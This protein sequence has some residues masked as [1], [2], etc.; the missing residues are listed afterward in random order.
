LKVIL[1]LRNTA[2]KKA[3]ES[4]KTNLKQSRRDTDDAFYYKLENIG[5]EHYYLH[6]WL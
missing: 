1:P 2:C 3:F 4:Y 6:I 5:A